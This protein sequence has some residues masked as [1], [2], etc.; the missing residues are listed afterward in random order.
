MIVLFY[1]IRTRT[2]LIRN[3]CKDIRNQL[4]KTPSYG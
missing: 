2:S 1:Q 4:K 3:N